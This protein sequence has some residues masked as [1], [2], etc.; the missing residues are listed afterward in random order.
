MFVNNL[1]ELKE[2][3]EVLLHIKGNL[4]SGSQP[5]AP[6]PDLI[7]KVGEIIEARTERIDGAVPPNRTRFHT[8]NYGVIYLDNRDITTI[9]DVTLKSQPAPLESPAG[10]RKSKKS[11]KFRKF[12]KSKKRKSKKRKY[13]KKL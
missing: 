3:T 5:G 7:P 11:R 9:V 6:P 4:N 13:S 10:G 1:N 12:R 2:G 8:K